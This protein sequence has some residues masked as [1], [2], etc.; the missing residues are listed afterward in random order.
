MS[1]TLVPAE[2]E[3][4]SPPYDSRNDNRLP[5]I[6][7]ARAAF[8]PVSREET[9]GEGKYEVVEFILERAR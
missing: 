3:S 6:T 5:F 1:A 2:E 4:K 9:P 7:E 8:V